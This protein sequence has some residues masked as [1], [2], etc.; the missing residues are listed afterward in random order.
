[1]H[2]FTRSL[3][4]FE[5]ILVWFGAPHLPSDEFVDQNGDLGNYAMRIT[6]I[7]TGQSGEGMNFEEAWENLGKNI[8][9]PLCEP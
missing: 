8:G 4:Q 1:M 5:R 2:M 7:P 9:I 3:F 6:Y